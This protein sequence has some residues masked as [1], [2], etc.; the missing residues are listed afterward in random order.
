[1]PDGLY[2]IQP[3]RRF[4][5]VCFLQAIQAQRIVTFLGPLRGRLL[6]TTKARAGEDGT[7]ILRVLQQQQLK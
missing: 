7:H 3:D 1:V 6:N 2:S 4:L 5:F